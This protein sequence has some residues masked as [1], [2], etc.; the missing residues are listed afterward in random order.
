M[1]CFLKLI[2]LCLMLFPVNTLL[3]QER[4]DMTEDQASA[5]R[6]FIDGITHFEEEEYEQA[7]DMLT[8]AHMKM[9]EEPGVNF[10]L[11][12]VYLVTGDL[13]NA[14]YYGKNAVDLDPENKW[15]H[16]KLA[17]IYNRAGRN[18]AT[19]NAFTNAL[20]YHPDDADLLFQLAEVYV[21]YGEL[22]KANRIYNRIMER[23]GSD[24]NLHLRKF[25]NFNALQMRDSALVEL[26]QMREIDPG[27]LTTLRTISQYYMELGETEM[28]VEV[29][30]DARQRNSRDPQTLLLLAEIYVN[31]SEW[32]ELGKVFVTM[33]EDPLIY[34]SQ[35]QE[36]VR[37]IYIQHQR[38]PAESS[39]AEQTAD[40]LM[41]FSENE[42]DY[43]PAQ[44]IAAEFFL[45]QNN[46]EAALEKL[47]QA[48]RVMP[49]QPEAWRQ[50]IQVLFSMERYDDVIELA[51]SADHHAPD[52]AFIQ[53]FTGASYMLNNRPEEA[54]I[55]LEQASY[56]PSNR[57]F[58]SVI[59]GTLGD[60]LQDLD[61]WEDA[62][63]AYEQALRLDSNNHNA[64]NNYAYFMSVREE[65]LDYAKELAEKAI[66]YEPE[67]AAYLDTV[68]WIYYKLGEY[69]QAKEYIRRS[70]ETGDASAE[71]YE[72]MGDVYKALNENENA[73]KYWN[74]AL[75]QDS[76]REY[77][78][79]RIQS[80]QS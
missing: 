3:A 35:K 8:Y 74:K 1:K 58:R 31:Q 23:R 33:L 29:L 57:N 24:F 60:V 61:R 50:R 75:D 77:L 22:L 63:D 67:N 43:G 12:D 25:R 44:I 30:D 16:L 14:A 6:A 5:T 80:A 32:E 65:R 39:L 55:W 9:P 49:E 47:E 52:D 41:A 21:D 56:A 34:P 27:N 45:E 7:L 64:M 26:E 66:S 42:P 53:F 13:T 20:E 73:I 11:A 76:D 62:R 59:N 70:L 28:A 69:E 78:N 17:E 68:G 19:I 2:L 71:V 72:H 4:S 38:N 48:N 46:L 10:A 51:D 40:V 79:E 15:Y 54:E 37:F 36:L 18:E